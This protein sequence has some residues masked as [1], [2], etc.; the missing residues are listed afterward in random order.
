MAN[1]VVILLKSTCWQIARFT[2][3]GIEASPSAEL[4]WSQPQDEANRIYEGLNAGATGAHRVL[5]ALD[6]PLCLS[7][8]FPLPSQR[9]SRNHQAVS[10]LLE[11]HLPW[12]A[13][14]VVV[15]FE[16]SKAEAFAVAVFHDPIQLLIRKLEELGV[17]VESISP[18]AR[19]ALDWDLEH[20]AI[21]EA[22]FFVLQSNEDSVELWMIDRRRPVLWRHVPQP[23]ASVIQELQVVALNECIPLPL[24]L[25]G[26]GAELSSEIRELP[27]FVVVDNS[28]DAS[29]SV[30][31]SAVRRA[32]AILSGAERAK[33]EFRRGT[34]VHPQRNRF[35]GRSLGLLQASVICL[36]VAIGVRVF[37]LGEEFNHQRIEAGDQ[38]AEVFRSL[39]P[40][41]P[42]P[43]GVKTRIEGEYAKL[44]GMR[45]D[46]VELPHNT[47]S[48][49]LVERLLRSLPKDMRFRVLE[50]RIEQDRL[51]VVGQV[52]EHADAD[53]IADELRKVNLVVEAPSTHRLPQKGVEFRISAQLPARVAGVKS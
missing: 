8:A 27:D 29:A 43:V 35:I 15:D 37:Q 25:R 11:P 50:I 12:S 46:I 17:L 52:R 49:R 3:R 1:A 38:Q 16:S 53:R 14:E 20:L 51:Y 26:I 9:Q 22:R 23:P 48:I 13:E 28:D 44:R 30:L 41:T 32:V 4:D 39:F 19:L 40:G 18:L 34:L 31:D 36:L 21:R 2:T 24:I 10:Y 42:I 7:A 33:I 47:S 5:I 45:G 6:S